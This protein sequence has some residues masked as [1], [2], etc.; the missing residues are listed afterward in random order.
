MLTT[1]QTPYFKQNFTIE[2]GSKYNATAGT[3][4]FD[5]ASAQN[6]TIGTTDGA[7]NVVFYNAYFDNGG[8]SSPKT[9][10]GNMIVDNT[11][12]IYDDAELRDVGDDKT[13][14][15]NSFRIDGICSLSGTIEA[16]GG[17][18]Y[19]N[20]GDGD[21]TVGTAD[22][23]V[24][25][26][27]YVG[28]DDIM[29]VN[30]NITVGDDS[31]A[32][33]SYLVIN[34]GSQLIGA[35]GGTLLVKN[36]KSLYIRDESN[37]PTGFGT[38]TFE[39]LSYTRYDANIANQNIENGVTYGRL[40]LNQGTS[41]TA[42]G[43]LDINNN[44][45]LY[46]STIFQMGGFS[47]T[48]GGSIINND[49]INGNGSLI[50]TGTVTLDGADVNQYIY[51]AGTGTYTFENFIL[52]QTAPTA[53]RYRRIYDDITVNGN[54]TATN[55]GGDNARRVIID[56]YENTITGTGNTLSL[57]AN[58][59]LWTSGTNNFTN[60]IGNFSTITLNTE[61]TVRFARN[62]DGSS[63]EI[64]NGFIYGNIELAGIYQK[65]PL[66]NLDI[67]GNFSRVGG[68]PILYD[69][70]HQI[71][72]AGDWNM[73]QIYTELSGAN[74]I[75]FDGTD[76]DISNSNFSNVTFH[77][78]GTKTI[79]GTLDVLNNLYISNGVIV[80]ANNQ[81]V[82]IEGNWVETGT[83]TFQQTGGRVTFDGTSSNQ[84][85]NTT[86]N[87]YFY[88]LTIDKR[89]LNKTVTANTNINITGTFD[90]VEDNASFNLNGNDLYLN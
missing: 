51:N 26:N 63:Q 86:A 80:E 37:F 5:G 52:T 56:I 1:S 8:G 74:H 42:L 67:N 75:V 58:V 38:I 87:S 39:D 30:G 84:T 7:P 44:L 23:I 78:S 55:S 66:E 54:F 12:Y 43:D 83:G 33:A 49:D 6:I 20:S 3:S 9:I 14:E 46:N 64:P 61:S 68:T 21:F 57:G 41:K 36:E 40:Y 77:N 17:T 35:A 18:F 48:I 53:T 25:Q 79:S 82:Y 29:R 4:V 31:E 27:L 65:T 16:M 72:V 32:Y 34:N 15:I 11:T 62:V 47:H 13:H 24:L 60:S 2:D 22:I 19:D 88:S 50:S 81:S 90:F 85:I 45:Y 69:N 70:S 71:N 73:N 59:S 10:D 28:S 76:Q 89:G